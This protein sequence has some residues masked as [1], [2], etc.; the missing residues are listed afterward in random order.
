MICFT[1]FV[2]RDEDIFERLPAN[3]SAGLHRPVGSVGYS[4]SDILVLLIYLQKLGSRSFGDG[5]F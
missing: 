3:S 4:S 2:D 1:R 5:S